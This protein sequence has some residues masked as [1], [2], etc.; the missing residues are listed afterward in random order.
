MRAQPVAL[1]RVERTFQQGAED[2]RFHVAPIGARGFNQ[3]LELI[4][5]EGERRRVLKQATVEA[6]DLLTQHGREAARLHAPPKLFDHRN[7]LLGVAV[8]AFEELEKT[9][10]GQQLHVF[11]EHG[12]ERPHQERGDHLSAVLARFEGLSQAAE[13]FGNLAGDPC[14]PPRGIERQGIGPDQAQ[15]FTC[16]CV[17]ELSRAESD[18]YADRERGRSC[19]PSG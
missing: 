4:V 16:L 7:K 6:Q 3:Q 12:E 15:R 14:A 11:R 1:H 5:V 9:V 17:V 18:G 2:G 13:L 19:R 8:Q 10:F